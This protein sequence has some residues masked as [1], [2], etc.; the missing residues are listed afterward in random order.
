MKKILKAPAKINLYLR[1]NG[2]REDGYHDLSMIMQPISLFD[3]IELEI[4]SKD[5]A[6]NSNSQIVLRC[7]YQF[8]PTDDKNLIVKVVKYFFEKY[9]IKDHIYIYLRK[10][11]PT[12]GGLGG[13]SSDAAT[14]LLFLNKYY[15]TGLSKD[16]L[17]N[18]AV[19][20]GADI[21]F[22]IYENECLCEGK[23]EKITELAKYN[24]YFVLVAT[25][26][27]RVSTKDIFD[28]LDKFMINNNDFETK[29]T[30]L[31]S[32]IDA[33]KHNNLKK[34]SDNIFNDLENVTFRL[35]DDVRVIKEHILDTGAKG[36]LM[37]GSGPSVYGIYDSY[38]K[39][40]K[41]KH[42][43]KNRFKDTFVY[44]AKPI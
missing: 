30:K 38:F 39:G 1:V 22:F 8:I 43:I 41:A 40:L 21:P 20:F 4:T 14:M 36:A 29:D 10:M 9:N 44:L 7:N 18:I 5:D 23:G 27:I 11:I 37:S 32:C 3:T 2:K 31:N 15:K 28:S 17:N 19:K 42:E 13:G 24:K 35:Y 34:L 25:P 26:N 6:T 33:I 16:E 12:C